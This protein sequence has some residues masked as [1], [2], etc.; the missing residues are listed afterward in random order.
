MTKGRRGGGRPSV[1]S[2]LLILFST[3]STFYLTDSSQSDPLEG[4]QLEAVPSDSLWAPSVQVIHHVAYRK[5]TV[6]PRL[7]CTTSDPVNAAPPLMRYRKRAASRDVPV[8][9]RPICPRCWTT[10]RTPLAFD[11]GVLTDDYSQPTLQ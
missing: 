3:S 10:Q 11:G 8:L 2:V 1:S 5:A 4:L 6:R 7:G 9:V